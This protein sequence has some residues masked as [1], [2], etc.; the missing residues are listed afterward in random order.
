MYLFT[1]L[2]NKSV[3]YDL[4]CKKKKINLKRN[5]NKII[6]LKDTAKKNNSNVKQKLNKIE[7]EKLF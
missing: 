2:V 1:Y 4:Q 3:A 5:L 6:L 7:I